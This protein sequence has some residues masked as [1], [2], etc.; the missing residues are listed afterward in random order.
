[1]EFLLAVIG[2]AVAIWMIVAARKRHRDAPPD[3]SGDD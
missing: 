1:M 3:G 2:I